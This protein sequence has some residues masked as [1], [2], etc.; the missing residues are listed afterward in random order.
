MQILTV[1]PKG[2]NKIEWRERNREQKRYIKNK[3]GGVLRWSARGIAQTFKG[4]FVR[5]I[6]E[7]MGTY[8]RGMQ[9][10]GE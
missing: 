3:V 5:W 6:I 10:L 8:R 7:P 4:E 9:R 1:R 2:M